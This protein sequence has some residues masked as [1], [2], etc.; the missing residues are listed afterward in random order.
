MTPSGSGLGDELPHQQCRMSSAA[1]RHVPRITHHAPRLSP[2][3]AGRSAPPGCFLLSGGHGRLR[4]ILHVCVR[5][6][7]DDLQ[8]AAQRAPLAP[9]RTGRRHGGGQV[10]NTN[11]LY[12]G[13]ES[14]D[15]G[16]MYPDYSW[17]TDTYAVP[18][19]SNGL[20]KWTLSCAAADFRSRWT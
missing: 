7:G 10:S 16:K 2:L 8:R 14:G 9:G 1:C 6:S 5:N 15:F 3:A 20:F 4:N 17:D 18:G 13:S 19:T 12:E 11:K